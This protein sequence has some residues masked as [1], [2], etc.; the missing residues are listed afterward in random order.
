LV[1][2]IF[3]A[4]LNSFVPPPTKGP[5]SS[6]CIILFVRLPVCL[7]A[8][9]YVFLMLRIIK[10]KVDTCDR[11]PKNRA[12]LY[13]SLRRQL[14]FLK[15]RQT[16]TDTDR[17]RQTQTDTNTDRHKHGHEQMNTQASIMK[18]CQTCKTEKDGFMWG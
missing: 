3:C 7:F 14:T 15:D 9:L 17:H 6:M 5:E 10:C 11:G 12:L 13:C 8:L 1:F 18:Y 2:C 16:Q 4:P